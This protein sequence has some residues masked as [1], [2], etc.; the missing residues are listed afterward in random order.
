MISG[1]FSNSVNWSV[2]SDTLMTCGAT[3]EWLRKTISAQVHGPRA[4]ATWMWKVTPTH[5]PTTRW[6]HRCGR[7][8]QVGRWNKSDKLKRKIFP[9]LKVIWLLNLFGHRPFGLNGD[10][11]Y[12]TYAVHS[13]IMPNIDT[14]LL[15]S[16]VIIKQIFENGYLLGIQ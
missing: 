16:F 7:Y 3:H 13:K 8:L 14:Y 11:W 5:T 4:N 2:L 15:T 9:F 6:Q 1:H 10:L 12:M